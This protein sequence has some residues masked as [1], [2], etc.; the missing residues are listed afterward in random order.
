MRTGSQ[1]ADVASFIYVIAASPEG[2]CKVGLSKHPDK[3]L[4]QLQTGHPVRLTLHHTLAVDVQ[5]VALLER[6]IHKTIGYRK[7]HGEW[8][9]MSVED[10]IGEVEFAMIRYGDY[11]N[12]RNFL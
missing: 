3:R 6:I 10:A 2:P 4:R 12:L 5:K 1:S 11:A 8:F 7:T 9:D